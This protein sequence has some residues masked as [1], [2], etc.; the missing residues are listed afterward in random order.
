MSTY[1]DW[2]QR[3]LDIASGAELDRIAER[4]REARERYDS[5]PRP[6]PGGCRYCHGRGFIS[7]RGEPYAADPCGYC[8]SADEEDEPAPEF[9]EEDE[10]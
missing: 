1:S 7:H 6:A 10:Q 8:D 5:E 2:D 3:Q 9:D 4:R